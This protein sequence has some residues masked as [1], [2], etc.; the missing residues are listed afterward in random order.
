MR[1]AILS[2][3]DFFYPPFSRWISQHTFRY[4]ATGGSTFAAGI[5]IY[6]IAYNFVL[7][8]QDI[9]V[10]GLLITAP[11]AAL[12][13]ESVITF[14]IGFLL[15]K[16][17]VFT[18]SNLKGR[19]QLFRYGSVVVTNIMLNYAFIKVMVEAFAFYTTIAKI[20]TSVILAVFSYFSQKHFSFRVKK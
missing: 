20:L 18:Q 3:I 15:N 7:K 2:L 14:L 8:Q 11:I 19:V 10:G 4:L 9:R 17:L 5:V 6:Y 1:K 12:A 13:I 16:Y